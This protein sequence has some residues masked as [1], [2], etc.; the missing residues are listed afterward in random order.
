MEASKLALA[1]LLG[2]LTT[3]AWNTHAHTGPEPGAVGTVT[4]VGKAAK[5]AV[6]S[7]KASIEI[8]ARGRNA[9]LGLWQR[10]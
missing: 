9:F 6:P 7:G 2:A 5:R 1:F 4:Q 8:L 10:C 3:L